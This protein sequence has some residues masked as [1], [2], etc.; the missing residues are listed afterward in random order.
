MSLLQCIIKLILLVN[1]SVNEEF[2]IKPNDI[3]NSCVAQS[4]PPHPHHHPP[5]STIIPP[6]SPMIFPHPKPS[7]NKHFAKPP[8]FQN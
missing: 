3:S 6:I 8:L 2:A 5:P 4:S 1:D 7:R